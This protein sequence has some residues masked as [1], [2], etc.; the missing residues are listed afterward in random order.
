MARVTARE[1]DETA[2]AWVA[3]LDRQLTA[4]EEREL[5]AWFAEDERHLGAF[6]RLHALLLHT[7]R[8]AG[9][10]EN[11][12][13]EQFR[14]PQAPAFS[15]RM[16][17]GS[18]AAALAAAAGAGVWFTAAKGAYST[19]RG[20][21]RVIPLSDG[22]VVTLNT[23]SRVVVRYSEASR[24]IS[25]EEGEA[26]F[27]VTKDPAR[28][29]VV[30]TGDMTVRA[31]GTSFTVRRMGQRPTQVLVREGV[32]EIKSLSARAAAPVRVSANMRA[33]GRLT[34][35]VTTSVMP[36]ADVGR[37]LLWREGRI[38]FEGES[39]TRAAAEFARYSDVRIVIDDAELASEEVS[40]MYAAND[41]IGFGRAVAKAFGAQVEVDE[42]EVRLYR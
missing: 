5:K 26:L 2:A 1:I 9:L 7:E 22:S 24:S 40:G 3:K 42:H 41:P 14:T 32:V 38:A 25:L 23:A 12:R 18:A 30:T 8:A 37:A 29:F 19:R 10:G 20:E 13:P 17:V 11:Y 6:G 28:P 36:P 34:Q 27:D 15:R 33:S 35:A 16:M 21:V 31:V 39:L 4:A